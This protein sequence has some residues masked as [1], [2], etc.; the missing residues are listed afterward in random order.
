MKK[1][2]FLIG[3]LQGGGAEK[4]L[5]DTVNCLDPEKYEITIQTL[6]DDGVHKERL[7]DKVRYKTIVKNKFALIKKVIGKL[8][9]FYLP[10]NAVY[11]F[12]IKDSYD[13]EIAFLEGLPTKLI[14]RS[15]ERNSK[16]IAWVH[17][18]LKDNPDSY[19]AFGSP[20]KEQ[21]AYECFDKV[22]CVSKAVEAAF[23]D[24]YAPKKPKVGTLYNILDDEAIIAASKENVILPTELKPCLISV[25]RLT[26]QKGYDRLLRIHKRLIDEGLMHS[27]LIIGEG[28]LRAEF[29]KYIDEN[30][31]S[32][33]VY[34][35]G[36]QKNP[37]KYIS[38]ADAFVCSSYAEGFSMVVTESV[39]CGTP[40]ISTDVSGIRE[41]EEAPRCS[42]IVENNE[43]SLYRALSE[44]I[45]NPARLEEY[46]K[47][48][49]INQAWFTKANLL[50]V[51]EETVFE[52]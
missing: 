31:L 27:L 42:M 45:M 46:R 9:F 48:L 13:Y 16:K 37:Y 6:F 40:V 34:L 43:E 32:N 36:F 47:S 39:L 41:P 8:L 28:E 3:S 25:G 33:S 23:V 29:E 1:V 14:S 21:A 24:K 18:D 7:S 11:N 5:I 10:S 20:Q 35:L 52:G 50:A 26:Q 44:V 38:K 12:F 51:F 30:D 22:F 19:R 17:T 15:T 49:W 4:V 2:L